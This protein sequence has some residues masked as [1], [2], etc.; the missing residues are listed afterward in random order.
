MKVT[1][2]QKLLEIVSELKPED[3]V[4]KTKKNH[5]HF[6]KV[7]YSFSHWFE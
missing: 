1:D 6:L 7:G 3:P 5:R 2:L 4:L